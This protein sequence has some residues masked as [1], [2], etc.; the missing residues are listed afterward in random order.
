MAKS[1]FTYTGDDTFLGQIEKL[2]LP[3]TVEKVKERITAAA[4]GSA[5]ITP[6][7]LMG[8]LVGEKMEEENLEDAEAAQA[9]ALNFLSL[10]NEAVAA[11][12]ESEANDAWKAEVQEKIEVEAKE[13]RKPYVAPVTPGRN[14]P[15]HCGGGKKFKKCH[16][17]GA[18][19]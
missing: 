18:A 6:T 13:A 4:Q 15:C 11:R 7:E 16:G 14:D 3:L 10:W 12:P 2:K 9:F 17:A 5:V 8:E 19:A 1:P